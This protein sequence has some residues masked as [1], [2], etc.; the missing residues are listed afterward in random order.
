LTFILPLIQG[1]FL[2][3]MESM[4]VK[5][6]Q[7]IIGNVT[8]GT[9]KCSDVILTIIAFQHIFLCRKTRKKSELII[10]IEILTLIFLYLLSN[11]Y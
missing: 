11:K 10:K 8:V 5:K 6:V 9:K 1:L 3:A 7:V 4:H 2:F